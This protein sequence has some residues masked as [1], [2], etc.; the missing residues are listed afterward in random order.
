VRIKSHSGAVKQQASSVHPEDGCRL[1]GASLLA[2][3]E[4]FV[5]PT[6][7]KRDASKRDFAL[8]G[9]STVR[10]GF[11]LKFACLSDISRIVSRVSQNSGQRGV[12]KAQI[13]RI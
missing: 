12:N 10:F 3:Q 11:A 4:T 1:R 8:S 2:G 6:L 7:V 9:S 5:Q 13:S